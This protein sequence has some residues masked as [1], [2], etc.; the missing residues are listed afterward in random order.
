M[1]GALLDATQDGV[2]VVAPLIR[3]S[4]H[5]HRKVVRAKA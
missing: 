2:V 1:V 5:V 3:V 4:I